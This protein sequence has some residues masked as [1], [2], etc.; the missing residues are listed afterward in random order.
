MHGSVMKFV[1]KTIKSCD[2]TGKS[3]IEIGSL[4]VNGSVRDFIE[5]MGPS[6]YIGID[7]VSGCGVD[8]VCTAEDALDV[9]GANSFDLIICTEMME[10][11]LNWQS[12][13]Y[14][15]KL[16]CK[17]G[18]V[19]L[20]TTR[21]NGFVYHPYN[22]DYWR[23][24]LDD[25]KL[26]FSDFYIGC[27]EED[28]E[29]PGV[30]VKCHKPIFYDN[31]LGR[32]NIIRLPELSR[33]LSD[34]RCIVS[35]NILLGPFDGAYSS[36]NGCYTSHGA[37]SVYMAESVY[38]LGI[39]PYVHQQSY[40]RIMGDISYNTYVEHASYEKIDLALI[41]VDP[42][43][44]FGEHSEYLECI[45]P[46]K[47]VTVC[48]SSAF[49]NATHPIDE[50]VRC[51][52]L[53]TRGEVN[54]YYEEG[55][56]GKCC[57]WYPGIDGGENNQIRDRVMFRI[58]E[59]EDA[60]LSFRVATE[61]R[62]R[63]PDTRI[64]A[65]GSGDLCEGYLARSLYEE[66]SEN[67][68]N[69]I[70]ISKLSR[71]MFYDYLDKTTIYIEYQR[72]NPLWTPAIAIMRGA[73]VIRRKGMDEYLTD[74]DYPFLLEGD[75]DTI[76]S[77]TFDMINT[78]VS[79][80]SIVSESTGKIKQMFDKYT[81]A[82]KLGEIL[83]GNTTEYNPRKNY[84]ESITLRGKNM[85]L[86]DISSV[87]YVDFSNYAFNEIVSYE[88]YISRSMREMGIKEYILSNDHNIYDMESTEVVSNGD[89]LEKFS[90][91]VDCIIVL[92]HQYRDPTLYESF[93]K[94]IISNDK[95]VFFTDMDGELPCYIPE[96][97]P[98]VVSPDE[99]REVTSWIP[100][101][102][103]NISEPSE[104]RNIVMG[105]ITTGENIRD[106]LELISRLH[107]AYPDLEYY[108]VNR[109]PLYSE[110][111]YVYYHNGF[112][113]FMVPYDIASGKVMTMTLDRVLVYIDMNTIRN[114]TSTASAIA[115]GAC[116]V[117][118]YGYDSY[119]I[120]GNALLYLVYGDNS[121]IVECVATP[122]V[123]SMEHLQEIRESYKSVLEHFDLTTRTLELFSLIESYRGV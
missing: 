112:K 8:I 5:R 83:Y 119:I 117:R 59:Y 49:A 89:E 108:V 18:G 74:V 105:Y 32:G 14:S 122:L 7:I 51:N 27:L 104:S 58:R 79:D 19:V 28:E 24:S 76:V 61:I 23:F 11:C 73:A 35:P 47:I 121:N 91:D 101:I 33:S 84:S 78:F 22:G 87:L 31:N 96:Y 52:I 85:H 37:Y 94:D 29:E 65:I 38:R 60:K 114:R 45:P 4:Y 71:S 41:T 6:S 46:D 36:N 115:R 109:S 17:E 110:Q 30:F 10:H 56:N 44:G 1:E 97:N 48:H 3:V 100:G 53:W 95:I 99:L 98:I 86:R 13:I 12:A 123:E 64:Y 111:D 25:I 106:T 69:V 54:S 77:S 50:S 120:E 103:P 68:I 62:K 116:V 20:I 21:S 107:E 72:N 93:V 66:F 80:P 70:P 92:L 9:F 43:F 82:T 75:D 15:I 63:F 40:Y 57:Y 34:A 113:D 67:G 118:P 88:Y 90:N 2:V 42:A 16:M 26:A 81:Q 55:H 102:E 39:V